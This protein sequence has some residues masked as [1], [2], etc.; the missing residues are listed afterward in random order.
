MLARESLTALLAA[1]VLAA[2]TPPAHAARTADIL[3][4]YNADRSA[5]GLPI[6][7]TINAQM[8]TGCANHDH[9]MALN[10][11]LEHGEDP[12][13]PGYTPEGNYQNGADG[14]EVLAED[15]AGWT[16]Q[17]DPWATAPIHLF[18]MFDPTVAQVGYADGYGFQCMRMRGSD[19]QPLP[20]Q[21]NRF[22][23]WT[24]DAGPSAVPYAEN[25]R[26][27]PYTPQQLVG[28]PAAQT[29]G[30]NMLLF[31]DG[32]QGVPQSATITGP[33]GQVDA[34][35]VNQDTKNDV[36]DGSWFT[37][38]GVIV[39]VHPLRP[40]TTYTVTVAWSDQ[41]PQTQT[42]SFTTIKEIKRNAIS[43]SL[44]RARH[45]RFVIHVHSNAP[46]PKLSL[47]GPHHRT[48]H[49]A[50]SHGRTRPLALAPG[51]WAACARSGGSG[52]YP[53]ATRCIV[54]TIGR[55]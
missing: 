7:S 6:V 31:S 4:T 39:P 38:G 3:P 49:P 19:S 32:D 26:E 12:S 15:P 13:K 36:G 21:P 52:G 27:S 29:T 51:R 55:R 47:A 46:N 41:G 50:V 8:E 37:G 20:A 9:Y 42:F 30:P 18:L 48:L 33:E 10:G 54:I 23:T 16:S 1:G 34:R 2:A 22:Y 45:G 35:L 40:S 5:N 53:P 17:H 11:G 28:I 24:S 44:S 25:A 43:L 14:S